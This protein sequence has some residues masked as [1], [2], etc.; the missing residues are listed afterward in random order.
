MTESRKIIAL[1]DDDPSVRG[2]L[3]RLL[4]VLGYHPEVFAS[5]QEFLSA[6]P[7]CKAACLI[8]DIDL[9]T[10]T[11]L[12]VARD[13]QVIGLN[14]PVIFMSGSS[15]EAI[16]QQALDAGG[17]EYLCKPVKAERLRAVIEKAINRDGG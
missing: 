11:G 8:F 13:A 17:A 16:R 3:S 7:N 14:L 12:E 4:W 2:A 1:V 6:T 10:T 15:D 9:G 5:G